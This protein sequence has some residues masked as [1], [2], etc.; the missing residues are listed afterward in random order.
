MNDP[1]D[2]C[3]FTRTKQNDRA[4]Y[5][6]PTPTHALCFQLHDTTR[7]LWA[8]GS[9]FDR[10]NVELALEMLESHLRNFRQMHGAAPIRPL[11]PPKKKRGASVETS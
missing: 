4:R 6:P 7:A 2:P 10:A 8:A 9:T 3:P 5:S 11:L 1:E